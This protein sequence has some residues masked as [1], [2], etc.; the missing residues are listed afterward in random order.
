M[1]PVRDRTGQDAHGALR[2]R[3]WLRDAGS[4][5]RAWVWWRN[6][7]VFSQVF[8]KK[9]VGFGG[10]YVPVG[11]C[12]AADRAGRR[13][14]TPRPPGVARGPG[15]R[16]AP[17][18]TGLRCHFGRCWASATGRQHPR[19]QPRP[20]PAFPYFQ[21]QGDGC[22]PLGVPQSPLQR[23]SPTARAPRSLLLFHRLRRFLRS[24][25]F[26]KSFIKNF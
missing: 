9:L 3:S 24:K 15:A 10:R 26:E 19:R 17:F 23:L 11:R 8:F 16:W 13:D 20:A 21:K 12:S 14:Q 1:C 4:Q 18:R 7:K 6:V 2:R 22:P 25:L 5:A